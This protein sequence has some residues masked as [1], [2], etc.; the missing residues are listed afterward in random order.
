MRV[1]VF[2]ARLCMP[3]GDDNRAS[4][5]C[6]NRHVQDPPRFEPHQGSPEAAALCLLCQRWS[7]PGQ[8]STNATCQHQNPSLCVKGGSL[9]WEQIQHVCSL[10]SHEPHTRQQWFTNIYL[11][12]YFTQNMVLKLSNKQLFSHLAAALT[13]LSIQRFRGPRVNAFVVLEFASHSQ[14]TQRSQ[15]TVRVSWGL[16]NA[17]RPLCVQ[18]LKALSS[19]KPLT[20]SYGQ[21][22]RRCP[23]L[24][25]GSFF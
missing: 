22:H 7:S 12:L 11:C 20:F 4:P 10:M 23:S 25:L 24:W 9:C 3:R 15:F 8:R 6:R 13:Q 18:A 19:W 14:T 21:L 1:C 17:E 2:F 5:F 16:C